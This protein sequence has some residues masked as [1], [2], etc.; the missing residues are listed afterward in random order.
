MIFTLAAYGLN[1]G[2]L[3]IIGYKINV[4]SSTD[5]FFTVI[6]RNPIASGQKVY[7]TNRFYYN[8]QFGHNDNKGVGG[9]D[10]STYHRTIEIT[11]NENVSVGET[12]IVSW[13]ST[14]VASTKGVAAFTSSSGSFDFGSSN[15][16]NI[17]WL[18]TESS[19][20]V[21][22][23]NALMYD[24]GSGNNAWTNFHDNPAGI[25]FKGLSTTYPSYNALNLNTNGN[26]RKCGSWWYNAV[27]PDF[28]LDLGSSFYNINHWIFTTSAGLDPCLQSSVETVL[29]SFLETNVQF[30]AVTLSYGK[31]RASGSSLVDPG[32]WYKNGVKQA[33]GFNP[34]GGSIST[35]DLLRGTVYIYDDLTLGS[36]SS[37]SSGNTVETF[38]IGKLVIIDSTGCTGSKVIIQPGDIL[39]VNY[40]LS[41]DDKESGDNV[42]PCISLSSGLDASSAM[43]FAQMSPTAAVLNGWFEY[44]LY[45]SDPGW[46]RISSP[47]SVPWSSV[48]PSGSNFTFKYGTTGQ[49]RNIYYYDASGP[50][51]GSGAVSFWQY[52][53]ASDDASLRPVNVYFAP[54][55][56]TPCTLKFF[57]ELAYKDLDNETSIPSYLT[58]NTSAI[59]ASSPGYNAPWYAAVDKN[60]WN[61]FGNHGLT[62]ISTSDLKNNYKD[63]GKMPNLTD[64]SVYLWEPYKGNSIGGVTSNYYTNNG[65]TGDTKAQY[66]PPFGAFFIHTTSAGSQGY[67][68]GRKAMR[69]GDYSASSIKHK[70]GNT[71]GLTVTNQNNIQNSVYVSPIPEHLTYRNGQNYNAISNGLSEG[72]LSIFEDSTFYRI[73]QT[74]DPIQY[75][76]FSVVLSS[77]L[78]GQQFTIG[79]H[80]DFNSSFQSYLLDHKEN[81]LMDLGVSD[82]SF[83]HDTTFT[84]ERFTWILSSSTVHAETLLGPP[85]LMIFVDREGVLSIRNTEGILEVEIVNA[86]GTVVARVQNS[87]NS[88]ELKILST[89][90]WPKGL[91]IVRASNGETGKIVVP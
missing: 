30:K 78:Q 60:G 56:E 48:D 67:V 50:L 33:A 79:N 74:E 7:V 53:N 23:I 26:S 27:N 54:G 24:E 71:L 70:T 21:T 84:M 51:N 12:F 59:S 85:G 45:I 18:Y 91:Y 15:Y 57:G 28:S 66:T 82:Y 10:R 29:V 20:T 90:K 39:D 36:F 37:A 34:W 52:V 65:A 5:G 46:H 89:S 40:S 13:T 43:H 41:M 32:Y 81:I 1:P 6:C 88:K 49:T 72:L 77:A 8:G 17:L 58:A 31:L 19:G 4:G 80:S 44:N 73:R 68:V 9:N 22:V 64:M 35:S 25:Y 62:F 55:G 42:K 87:D 86:M 75:K 2:D 83:I 3:A 14:T 47:I 63:L 69:A 61:L 76:E 38:S 16:D 11:F